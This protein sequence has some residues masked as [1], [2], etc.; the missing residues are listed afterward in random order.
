[1]RPDALD[2]ALRRATRAGDWM[3]AERIG[4]RIGWRLVA[5]ALRRV[6]AGRAA[7][8]RPWLPPR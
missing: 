3:L 1:M 6:L 5:A 2:P 8:A 7:S 4:R